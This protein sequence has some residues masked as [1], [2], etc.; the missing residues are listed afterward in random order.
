MDKQTERELSHIKATIED[1]TSQ[2]D[3]QCAAEF[4]SELTD[5]AYAKMDNFIYDD[6]I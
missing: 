3:K 5:W 4:M 6:E 2:M 1:K